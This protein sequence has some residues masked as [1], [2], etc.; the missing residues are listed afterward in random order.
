MRFRH[1]PTL[2][3]SDQMRIS[4]ASASFMQHPSEPDHGFDTPLISVRPVLK[5]FFRKLDRLFTAIAYAEAGNLDAVQE[6]LDQDKA[7]K[8]P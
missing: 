1:Q 5:R 6:M 8:K 3:V 7:V 4:S 2:S